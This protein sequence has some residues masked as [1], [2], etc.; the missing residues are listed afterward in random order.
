MHG[1]QRQCRPSWIDARI[2]GC[3]QQML[4]YTTGGPSIDA[5]ATLARI[6]RYT[7]PVP[8]LEVLLVTCD[9][10]D[11]I[12]LDMAQDL[13]PGESAVPAVFVI[14]EGAGTLNDNVE[15]RPS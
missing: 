12:A 6:L 4:T 2:Q 11:T 8:E 15:C 14:I 9:P 5:G 7:P 10:G 13:L 1:M 3:G